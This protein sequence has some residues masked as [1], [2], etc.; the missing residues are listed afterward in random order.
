[1]VYYEKGYEIIILIKFC[2]C[3]PCTAKWS[4][5]KMAS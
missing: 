1:M 5:D 4:V 2:E 3:A